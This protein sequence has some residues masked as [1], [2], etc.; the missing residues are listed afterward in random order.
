MIKIKV[1]LDGDALNNKDIHTMGQVKLI[2]RG[3]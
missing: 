3:A 1:E 2:L